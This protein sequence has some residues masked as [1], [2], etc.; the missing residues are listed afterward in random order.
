V[1]RERI[2][3]QD[4][5]RPSVDDHLDGLVGPIV[6]EEVDRDRYRAILVIGHCNPEHSPPCRLALRVVDNLLYIYQ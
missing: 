1:R 6:V 4:C 5:A 3:L 2:R